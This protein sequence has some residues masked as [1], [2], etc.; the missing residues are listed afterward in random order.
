MLRFYAA[1]YGRLMYELSFVSAQVRSANHWGAAEDESADKKLLKH[2]LDQLQNSLET[3]PLSDVVAFQAKSLIA[4]IDSYSPN[5]ATILLDSLSQSITIDLASHLYLHINASKRTLFEQPEPVFGKQV[6]DAFPIASYDVSEAAKCVALERST[7]AVFHLMRVT[8]AALKAVAYYLSV[9]APKNPNWGSWLRVMRDE[10]LR[11]G[12]DWV[13]REFLQDICARLDAIKDAY[14][15]TAMHIDIIYTEEE[16]QD[17]FQQTKQ[18]MKKIASRL[19]ENGE[20][21]NQQSP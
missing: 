10:R 21:V 13:D 18:F 17:L 7:A 6:A 14:R 1:S 20:P 9:E 5:E 16:A 12:G 2:G 3:L 11:R 19:D 8:E 4:K 15:N